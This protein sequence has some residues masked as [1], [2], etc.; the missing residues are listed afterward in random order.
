MNPYIF[1][2][3]DIRGIVKEDFP[4]EVVLLLGKAFGTYVLRDGGSRI[5]I[6][7]D[8][9]TTTP[10]MMDDFIQGLIETGIVVLDMGIATTPANYFSMFHYEIDGAVQITGSHN[11]PEFNGFKLSMHKKPVYGGQIQLLK[12]FID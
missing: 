2:E 12:K 3:Y 9:R 11:P 7:G 4:S 5:S 1:R 8:V 10:Q 6:S